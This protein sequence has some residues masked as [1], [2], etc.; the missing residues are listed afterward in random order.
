MAEG[1][2]VSPDQATLS[3]QG[4]DSSFQEPS[5]GAWEV[6]AAAHQRGRP[7]GRAGTPQR[8]GIARLAPELRTSLEPARPWHLTQG[9][10]HF[11]LGKQQ[12]LF[13]Q[14]MREPIH[15]KPPLVHVNGRLGFGVLL[16]LFFKMKFGVLFLL[17]PLCEQ[18][19]LPSGFPKC[20]PAL[21]G[22]PPL[23]VPMGT[24]RIL[25]LS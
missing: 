1:G 4:G 11:G 15:K 17:P 24:S 9:T 14:G 25:C 21:P 10:W 8:L 13:P 23:H 19:S 22:L 3:L 6:T 2:A 7:Q 5:S 12:S 18:S 20:C 16:V